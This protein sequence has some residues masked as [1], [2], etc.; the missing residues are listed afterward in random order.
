MPAKIPSLRPITQKTGTNPKMPSS[1]ILTVKDR[2]YQYAICGF[3]YHRGTQID[4]GHYIA[5]VKND[6]NAWFLVD[7]DKFKGVQSTVIEEKLRT[8]CPC[9][10]AYVCESK[11][12]S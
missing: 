11:Q 5:Y 9:I 8:E 12:A 10:I 7:D 2:N 1:F 4:V 3:A 6:N